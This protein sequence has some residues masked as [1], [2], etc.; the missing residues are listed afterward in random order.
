MSTHA[1]PFSLTSPPVRTMKTLGLVGGLTYHATLLYYKQINDRVQERLGGGHSA[2][3]VIRSFDFADIMKH[4]NGGDHGETARQLV[5]AAKNLKLSGAEG[6]ALCVNTGHLFA[7]QIEKEVGLPL[8]HIIDFA[9]QAI[10]ANGLSRVALLG[11]K[12]VMDGDSIVGRLQRDF[13]VEVLLPDSETRQAMDDVIFGD[14]ASSIV[15]E[16]TRKLYIDTVNELVKQGAQGVILAC[17]ELQFV[18]KPEDVGVPL[19]DTVELHARGLAEWM[20][21]K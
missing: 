15:S 10:T 7:D 12:S 13:G 11:T 21:Q 2:S 20:L 9:G 16:Q 14:L 17:T 4:F 18:L 5:E 3:L 19:F 1:Q 8:L 6:I